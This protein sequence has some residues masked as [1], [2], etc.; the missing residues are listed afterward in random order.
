MPYAVGDLHGHLGQL[1][2]VLALIAA[3][4]GG[5]EPVIFLGDHVDRGPDA[6]GVLDRFIRG[7]DAGRPW[8]PILGNHDRMFFRFLHDGT[9]ND[10]RIRSGRS[11]L[12]PAMG[13]GA[14]LASY[15]VQVPFA[16]EMDNERGRTARADLH[17]AARKAV[18]EAHRLFLDW[19]PTTHATPDQVFVHAG[20][21]PGVPLVDQAEDDLLWMRE[22]FLSDTRNHGALVV[23]GHTP[24]KVAKHYGN[25]LNLDSGAGLGEAATVAWIDGSRAW[26]LSER[27]RIALTP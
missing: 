15:G 19:L 23:H 27:G 8:H 12:H 7:I 21:R 4:G 16:A 24:V 17:R 5:A 6:R 26:M 2:R 1:D 10:P 11:W 20:L 9:V 18:P 3:D 22:P 13:G 14:T 25:R